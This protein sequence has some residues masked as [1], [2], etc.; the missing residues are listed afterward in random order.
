MQPR[1]LSSPFERFDLLSDSGFFKEM[2]RFFEDY[3]PRRWRHAN[4]GGLG[5]LA[6]H[7]MLP[8]EGKSPRVD[9]Q[10]RENDFL[11]KS[12]MP[13]VEKKDIIITISN[14]TLTL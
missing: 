6:G 12:E 10:D 13:G 2:D 8:F 3:L 9:I 5:R 4:F 7:G 11:I 14:N 1:G